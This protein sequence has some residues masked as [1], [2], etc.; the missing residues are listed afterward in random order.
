MNDN[1]TV[2]LCL[3]QTDNTERTFKIYY[4]NFSIADDIRFNFK[5]SD[6]PLN[7]GSKFTIEWD[8]NNC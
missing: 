2:F 5:C 6:N 8:N 1:D 7:N 3:F 4:R